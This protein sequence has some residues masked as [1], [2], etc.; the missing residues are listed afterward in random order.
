VCGYGVFEV[1]I[2]ISWKKATMISESWHPGAVAATDDGAPVFTLSL[3]LV[4]SL[5]LAVSLQLENKS[6]LFLSARLL[7][8]V[9]SAIT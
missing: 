9:Q 5:P 6:R 8:L 7:A 2:T 1:N 3:P 4:V